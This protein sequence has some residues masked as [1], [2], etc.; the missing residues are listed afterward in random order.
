MK[1]QRF[2]PANIKLAVVTL[3]CGSSLVLFVAA[4]QSGPPPKLKGEICITKF[5]DANKSG[6]QDSGEPGLAG[7]TFKLMPGGTTVT[8]L[9]C[10]TICFT[11]PAPAIYTVT[12]QLQPG[13]IPV[14]PISKT[15]TVQPQKL[16]NVSF[17]NKKK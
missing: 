6:V 3:L 7:W 16:V 5:L 1:K 17:G 10:G 2:I 11:M 8:T 4:G 14:G 15:V 12:E 9:T 13:W